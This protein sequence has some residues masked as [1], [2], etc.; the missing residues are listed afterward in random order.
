MK[1][2]I[3]SMVLVFISHFVMGQNQCV[4]KIHD[5]KEQQQLE[6]QIAVAKLLK[7]DNNEV[8]KL[9]VVI[10]ILHKGGSDSISTA[11]AASQI[12]FNN[13][14]YRAQYGSRATGSD[15]RMEYYLANIKPD[16][17]PF[18]GIIHH[19]INDLPLSQSVKDEYI[20]HGINAGTNSLGVSDAT[21]KSVIF[22]DNQKYYNVLIV[23]EIDG[24]NAGGGVQGY[25]F[26]PTTSVSD[27][28]VQVY[29][30]WGVKD[31]GYYDLNGDGVTAGI[32]ADEGDAWRTLKSYT[33][34]GGT[35]VH[36][37][38]HTFALFHTFQGGSCSETNCEIQGDRV[39]DTPPTTLNSSCTPACSG[40]QQVENY[41]DYTSQSCKD[42]LTDGQIERMRLTWLN[43]RDEL[44]DNFEEVHEWRETT[45]DIDFDLPATVCGLGQDYT[46]TVT[47]TG[48]NTLERIK[49]IYGSSYTTAD[50][51]EITMTLL[52]NQYRDVYLPPLES[53]T[54]KVGVKVIEV[55]TFPVQT[56][57]VID[58][59]VVG[60][61]QIVVEFNPDV[62]GGQ[63][64]WEINRNGQLVASRNSYPNFS[65]EEVFTDTVCVQGGCIDFTFTDIVG[66]GICC[67]NGEGFLNIYVNGELYAELPDDF[68]DVWT[69]T[70]CQNQSEVIIGYYN[71][72]GEY[73][74]DTE[75]EKGWYITRYSDNSTTKHYKK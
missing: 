2:L 27:G 17:T 23:S 31:N 26:F 14:I 39:C 42:L 18:N 35:G 67:Q 21:L 72:M 34:L 33:N 75:P 44:L 6:A 57:P 37:F 11:Q 12:D 43:S 69:L 25:A 54:G 22:F 73:I 1:N 46:F 47:N 9:P 24:N 20:A 8:L 64:G 60:N 29:N 10:H 19:N 45:V 62:L 70:N 68:T 13:Q 52:P 53:A 32:G 61:I 15:A 30:S 56:E 36:E 71:F 55:N 4:V 16:G 41:M 51:V 3:F 63:N 50:T 58:Q 65:S 66:N 49:V 5:E 59:S 40:Q 48:S 74:G 7:S 28:I 38:G